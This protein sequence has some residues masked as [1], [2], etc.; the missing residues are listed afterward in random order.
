MGYTDQ[1]EQLYGPSPQT[2]RIF[3][4]IQRMERIIDNLNLVY[5]LQS[6]AFQKELIRLE[7]T[8]FV[9]Q[10]IAQFINQHPE[11]QLTWNL[12]DHPLYALAHPILLERAIHNCLLNSLIHN[13]NSPISFELQQQSDT[14]HIF[15]RDQGTISPD[16]VQVLQEKTNNLGNH[17]M[18]TLI[19]KQIMA[20]HQ[21]E[22]SFDYL[23]PGL[24]VD[25]HFPRL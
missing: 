11:T 20:L 1:L 10:V 24:E 9:R 3:N 25:L 5:R 4:S 17:G 12:P 14:L 2:Q 6:Q 21:G 19:T 22:A 16:T 23:N 7:M 18:G 13:E 8:A 15:I